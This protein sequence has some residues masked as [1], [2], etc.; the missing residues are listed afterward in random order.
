[1]K[2]VYLLLVLCMVAIGLAAQNIVAFSSVQGQS[3]EEVT[4]TMSLQN[5]DAI[6][7][8]QI[9]MPLGD[10][11]TYVE[12][13][14]KVDNSR[15]A[16][17]S[18]SAGVKDSQLNIMLYSTGMKAIN[19]SDGQ[20]ASFRLR[21]GN[22]PG[23]I[24]IYPSEVI[25]T[26]TKGNDLS[27]SSGEC[28]VIILCAKAEYSEMT[29]DFGKL[30]VLDT[31]SK[32]INVTNVGNADL[33]ITGLDFSKG[34]VFSCSTSFP[35]TISSGDS[36]LLSIDCSPKVR[37]SIDETMKVICNSVS[38][39]NTI[40]LKAEAFTVNEL[41]IQS[42][43]G[44]ADE[45]VTVSMIMNNMDAVN[46]C[47]VIF[48]MPDE[49]EYVNGSF[50]LSNR[51]AD[52]ISTAS[53]SG[54]TL[55]LVIYSQTGK[56]FIGNDGEIGSFKVKLKGRNSVELKPSKTVLSATINNKV[57]NVTSAVYGGMVTINSPRISS[58]DYLDFGA[59]PVTEAAERSFTINN[60]G[61][62]TLSVSRIIFDNENLS[63]KETLPMTVAVGG[64]GSVTVVYSSVEQTSFDSRMQIYSNDPDLRM[65][66]VNVT[67]SRFAPNYLEVATKDISPSENMSIDFS[68]NTYDAVKGLQFDVTYPGQYYTT[69]DNNYTLES[70]AQGM[71]VNIRQTDVNTFKVFCY[72]LNGGGISAGEGKV[73]SLLLKPVGESVPEGN[74][75]VYVRNIKFGTDELSN[76]YAGADCQSSF[77]VK[78]I[79]PVT[80]T[81]K[82]YTIAYGDEIPTFE[83]TSEGET[84][85]GIPSISCE[86][87]KTSP[88][89]SYSIIISKGTV[90]NKKDTYVNGTLTITKAPLK[91][92]AKDY[93][94]KQ[95]EA[96][97]TFEATYEGFKNNETSSVFTK[98]PTFSC[99]AKEG[100]S[101]GTYDIVV[102][103]TEAKNYSFTYVKGKLTVTKADPVTVT[104]KS[105]EI[106]Y[107][108]ALP[109]YE[110][111]STGAA[112]N[113]TPTISCAATAKSPAGTYPITIKKGSV[114]NYNDKYVNGTLTIKKAPLT[115]KA[116]E[117]TK[118]QGE[119]NPE[120]TLTYEGFKHNET[121]TVL[122]KKPTVSTLAT[123]DSEPGD[124]D[125]TVSGAEA[126]NYEI[127]YV[128]GKLTI[129]APDL[130][131]GDANGDGKVD[132]ADI[133]DIV[134]YMM[135]KPT[136]TGKFS[137]NAA[138]VN[139]DN[140][141]NVAD[142]V[143][144]ANIIMGQ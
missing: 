50:T 71:T 22:Q 125:V 142:I 51:T 47:Q 99:S 118:K 87:T 36:K 110:Y 83:Y 122:T 56:A 135:G 31:G 106:T 43:E 139:D 88:V 119:D 115:I 74:Y 46:G 64:S 127:S 130:L 53:Q 128:K 19:G 42:V 29:V 89:G 126:Q 114:T 84:L 3:G 61:N 68:L 32:D 34:D 77:K 12:G 18:I 27:G 40:A 9:R 108:D 109:E 39:L 120:F 63:V 37:G 66:E 23:G 33:I 137:E 20:I 101:P 143:K 26:G 60:D 14:A 116:G 44:I 82:S 81:A 21:L 140:V 57:D 96:L 17:H 95:G 79:L 138:D 76:K 16:N 129:Q 131:P 62:A 13:S 75:T 91:I 35:I 45:E 132:A 25:M 80:I 54:R 30:S 121:E 59:V 92:T 28:S 24:S 58:D 134:N 6:S 7:A 113:G 136:S 112:L 72:F 117:Y 1:M 104:A 85:E 111:T 100:S 97:P 78:E 48:D 133:A 103:G 49:L 141:V 38:K 94:I 73:M 11:L 8:I 98:Q 124:Y 10:N 4:V 123:K 107:G 55:Q 52:H 93:T 144:I 86:A 69:F 67:G 15:C 105:Y 2:R 65:K 41:H 90:T 102:S 5:V 70:R